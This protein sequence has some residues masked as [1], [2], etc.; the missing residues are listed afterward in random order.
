MQK[1]VYA[2]NFT[3]T[4]FKIG[5]K[6]RSIEYIS[7]FRARSCFWNYDCRGGLVSWPNV[8]T[9]A[10]V[11]NLAITAHGHAKRPAAAGMS[12]CKKSTWWNRAK[13]SPSACAPLASARC[14]R[15]SKSAW[16]YRALSHIKSPD[17]ISQAIFYGMTC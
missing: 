3:L 14:P 17:L 15:P 4:G 13:L 8:R 16:R 6:V 1:F 7:L 10:A 11:R 9:V 12:T 2:E 5:G